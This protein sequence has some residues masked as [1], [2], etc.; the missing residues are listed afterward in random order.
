MMV[1]QRRLL[2]A[3]GFEK[4]EHCCRNGPGKGVA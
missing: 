1:L 2:C 3:N 4:G